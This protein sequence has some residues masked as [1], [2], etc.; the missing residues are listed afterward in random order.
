M[1]RLGKHVLATVAFLTALALPASAQTASPIS[2]Q[3]SGLFN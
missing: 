2:L 1:W 3:I